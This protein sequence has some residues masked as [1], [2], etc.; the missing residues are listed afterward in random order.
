MLEPFD[1]QGRPFPHRNCFQRHDTHLHRGNSDMNEI[2]RIESDAMGSVEIPAASYWGA[3]T[4]RAVDNFRISSH[5]MPGEFKIAMGIIKISAARANRALGLLDADMEDVLMRAGEEI[6]A[7][8][9]DGNFPVDVF[10]T[11]SGTSWNMNFNEVMA[12]RA[13]E[14]LGHPLG[15]RR[16]VHPNDHVNMGQSSN[17]VIPTAIN[18]ANR[19]MVDDLLAALTGLRAAIDDKAEEFRD[20]VKLGRTHLQDAV[21][22]TVGQEFSGW[23]VQIEKAIRRIETTCPALEELALGGTALGTGINTHPEFSELAIGFM[24]ERT[25]I[26][27]RKADNFFEAIANRDAQVELMGALNS[28]AVSLMKIAQD[29]RLLSSGPRGAL[30]EITLPALQPGSSIMPGKVNPVIP[31]TVIQVCAFVMGKVHAVTIA[32]QNAPLQLNMMQPLIA[33]ETI[34]SLRVLTRAVESLDRLC[35]SGIAVDIERCASWIEGSLALVTPLAKKIGYDR[36][37]QIAYRAFSE[38][39]TVRD[40]LREDGEVPEA[41]IEEILNPRNML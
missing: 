7:G 29:L 11:G 12:N 24:A 25:G 10:Q 23:S 28:A 5:T 37:A 41:E 17:D 14:M 22:M 2:K 20:V 21:P 1:M 27:F 38:K 3:Q 39:R 36:A 31:E 40:I 4:Q 9:L 33:H 32:G 34:E 15:R 18:I 35:M 19:M 26:P 6:L 8:A 30:G 16:P 13:N